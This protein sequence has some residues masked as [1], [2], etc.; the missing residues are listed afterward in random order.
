MLLGQEA[1]PSD[2]GM[3]ER[4]ARSVNLVAEGFQSSQGA[5]E[6]RDTVCTE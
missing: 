3:H 5:P 4:H 6:S 1:F 2:V